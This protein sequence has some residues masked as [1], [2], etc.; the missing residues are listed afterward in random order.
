MTTEEKLQHFL[1]FCMQD[2]RERSN[3]M[4][5][6]YSK[7][8]E[9]DFERHQSDSRRRAEIQLKL[10]TEKIE[11]DI[12][13]RLSIEQVNLKRTFSQKQEEL[14]NQLFDELKDRLEHFMTQSS[15]DELLNQQIQ[16]AIAFAGSDDLVIYLDPLDESKAHSLSLRHHANIK[17][18]QYSFMGG[19]RAVIAS[20]NILIDNSF[21]T[22]LEDARQAFHFDR[23]EVGSERI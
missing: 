23:N 9:Q 10:E 21:Q 14:K 7:A 18:S 1:D 17:I 5:N 12:N 16:S 15:Y 19:T 11:R 4:L 8:L 22:R 2:A 6:D 20:K 13:R 3:D